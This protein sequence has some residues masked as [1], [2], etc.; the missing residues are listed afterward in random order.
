M[1]AP[2]YLFGT[3][4]VRDQRAFMSLGPVLEKIQACEA[5]AAEFHLGDV[6]DVDPQMMQ[7]PG[8]QRISSL[9][10]KKRYEKYRHILLKATG[11]DLVQFDNSLPFLVVNLATEHLLASEMPEPLD[12]Y[13]WN[14][15]K[16]SGKSLHGIET[17]QE[18]MEVLEKI[19]LETQL[20][21]L[22]GL[23]RN[24]AK[25][26]QYLLRL[27]D[28]YEKGNAQL[29]YK[30]VKQNTRGLRQLLLYRRNE[31]MAERIHLMAV[32]KSVFAAIGA[33]HLGG[34]KGVLRLLKK[35]GYRL[36]PVLIEPKQLF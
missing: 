23:C 30:L 33:A 24:T 1:A 2:S 13:L 26:R 4:H 32:E 35:K 16:Q 22:D 9:F 12:A 21:M 11:L 31:I 7:I 10:P 5:F 8:G 27:A 18:Q 15:A 36:T 28:H 34:G 20:K 6:G 19:N 14:L 25:F 17:F 3:M 29:L